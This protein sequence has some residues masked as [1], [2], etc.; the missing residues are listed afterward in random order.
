M[1]HRLFR[2]YDLVDRSSFGLCV[3]ALLI[4]L[5]QKL[6]DNTSALL[7]L[8]PSLLRFLL[9]GEELVVYFPAH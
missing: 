7:L 1:A 6:V 4:G 5:V 2:R 9:F 3:I 8:D